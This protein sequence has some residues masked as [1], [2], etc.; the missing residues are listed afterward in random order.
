MRTQHRAPRAG[1]HRPDIGEHGGRAGRRRASNQPRRGWSKLLPVIAFL[2]VGAVMVWM[3]TGYGG[4]ETGVR[5][6]GASTNGSTA[7]NPAGQGSAIE[8]V[9]DAS[10]SPGTGTNAPST[11]TEQTK[12]GPF[13]AADK[14]FLDKVWQAGSWEGPTGRQAQQSASSKRVKDVGLILAADHAQLDAKV[15]AVATQLGHTL[16]TKPSAQQQGWM[17]QLSKVQGTAY[18]ALFADLLRGAH[19]KVFALVA[20]IRA[21][22]KNGLVRAF[23]QTANAAVLKHMTLLE[24]TGEV[25]FSKLPDAPPP[26]ATGTG[27]NVPPPSNGNAQPSAGQNSGNSGSNSGQNLPQVDPSTGADLDVPPGGDTTAISPTSSNTTPPGGGMQNYIIVIMLG[28][29]GIIS[30]LAYRQLHRRR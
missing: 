26:S 13:S 10:A 1:Q 29:A 11:G 3:V 18:D 5:P 22:T 24:S 2:A 27:T 17:D 8:P 21:G 19:G 30:A 20:A 25:D 9:V 6:A 7:D 12:F 15:T 14:D 4:T 23:A 28:V 16:P